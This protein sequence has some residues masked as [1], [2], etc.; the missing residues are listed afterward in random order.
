MKNLKE[1]EHNNHSLFSTKIGLSIRYYLLWYQ[2]IKY[3]SKMYIHQNCKHFFSRLN[4]FQ[5]LSLNL[6]NNVTE[7]N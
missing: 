7:F 6:K 5:S 1:H 4:V 3:T 2:C